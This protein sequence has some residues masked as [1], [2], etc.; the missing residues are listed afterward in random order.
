MLSGLWT[1]IL[2]LITSNKIVKVFYEYPSSVF[3]DSIN[4]IIIKFSTYA[5]SCQIF[6]DGF[7]Y[8]YKVMFWIKKIIKRLIVILLFYF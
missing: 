8:C 5:E 3:Y 4:F 6:L 7:I 2:I 1:I